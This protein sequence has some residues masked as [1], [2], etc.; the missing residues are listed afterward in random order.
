MSTLALNADHDFYFENNRIVLI[1]GKDSDEEIKQRIRVRL[2]FFLDSWFLNSSHGLPYFQEILG[3][4]AISLGAVKQI[5]SE[6]I[7]N[8]QG[9]AQ[10]LDSRFDYANLE[11][12]FSYTFEALTVNSTIITD[13]LVR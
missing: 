7:S 3:S 4:K 11:R 6:N 10:L 2:W 13:Q 1:D 9:V 5:F 12:S 8:V